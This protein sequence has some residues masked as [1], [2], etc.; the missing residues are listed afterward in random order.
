VRLVLAFLAAEAER[1]PLPTVLYGLSGG[2]MLAYH[3]AAAATKGAVRGIVGMTFL[4]QRVQRVLDATAHDRLTSRLGVPLMSLAA[5]T[6]LRR[7]R[8]PMTLASKMSALV[9]DPGALR[10]MLNDRSSAG[11]WAS[12]KFLAEYNSYA[13]AVEPADFDACP[14]L[15]TQPAAD[16]WTPYELSLPVLDRITKVP[17]QRVMLENA[18]HYPLEEPGLT[19]LADAVIRFV[20]EV[21]G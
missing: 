21:A 15:L 1:H 6:P 16:P 20:R 5:R 3:V 2:G 10:V 9:N 4:D 7:L 19:Q 17:V 18:G 12:V 13:P 11:N 14:V 8:Y